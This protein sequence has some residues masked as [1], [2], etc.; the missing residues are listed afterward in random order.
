MSLADFEDDDGDDDLD[1]GPRTVENTPVER[2]DF[3][4]AKDD[5]P[6][7]WTAA[8][9]IPDHDIHQLARDGAFSADGM[10]V[11]LVLDEDS[12]EWYGWCQCTAPEPCAHLC[13]VRQLSEL[14][15]AYRTE[16]TVA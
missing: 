7:T 10:D 4:S 3:G 2:L 13:A 11:V 8:L 14:R 16:T 5:R 6:A 12:G 9:D 15:S 1:D